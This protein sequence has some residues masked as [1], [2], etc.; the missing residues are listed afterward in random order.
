[1]GPLSRDACRAH[2]A[3]LRHELVTWEGTVAERQRLYAEATTEEQCRIARGLVDIARHRCEAI[4]DAIDAYS[5]LASGEDIAP[6]G[7]VE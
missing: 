3:S 5:R 1:M 4:E 2:A 6:E 7:T